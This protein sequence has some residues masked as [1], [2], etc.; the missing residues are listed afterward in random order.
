MEISALRQ[1]AIK[2]VLQKYFYHLIFMISPAPPP[3][4]FSCIQELSTE[5][6]NEQQVVKGMKN[7]KLM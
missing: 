2:F 4:S 1:Q 7:K 3:P 5:L 6:S